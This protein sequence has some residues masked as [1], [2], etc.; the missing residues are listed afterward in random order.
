[1]Y[2][3]IKMAYMINAAFAQF[4]LLGF[5]LLPKAQTNNIINPTRGIAVIIS[6]II[7]SPVFT[8]WLF[9]F[10]ILD[11][12]KISQKYHFILILRYWGR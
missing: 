8:V 10:S 6:V 1:M 9:W 7:Q 11:F 2:K 3:E 12:L 5:V 4:A